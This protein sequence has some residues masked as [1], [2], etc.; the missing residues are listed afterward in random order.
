MSKR[1]Y[2]EESKNLKTKRG[3]GRKA[4][5]AKVDF[6]KLT[7]KQAK[8]VARGH[9]GHTPKLRKNREQ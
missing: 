4:W 8:H 2:K 6:D 7:K 1:T 9:K 3:L 5:A